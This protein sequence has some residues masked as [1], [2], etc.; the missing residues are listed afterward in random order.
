MDILHT[1]I[2]V[3]IRIWPYPGD[4]TYWQSHDRM[5]LAISDL[6]ARGITTHRLFQAIGTTF[7]S[8]PR[9]MAKKQSDRSRPTHCP[10]H[11]RQKLKEGESHLFGPDPAA[12]EKTRESIPY[13]A[14]PEGTPPLDI[15][16]LL[17]EQTIPLYGNCSKC[18]SSWSSLTFDGTAELIPFHH[19]YHCMVCSRTNFSPLPHIMRMAPCTHCTAPWTILDS[20]AMQPDGPTASR[21]GPAGTANAKTDPPTVLNLQ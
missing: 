12:A 21:S 17:R 10:W 9:I 1:I 20:T 6:M 13:Q 8:A 16:H 14:D 5:V 11:I 15:R 18:Q 19:Q 3:Q 4:E 7:N 2:R